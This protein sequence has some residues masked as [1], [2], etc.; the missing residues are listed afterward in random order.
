VVT[1]TLVKDATVIAV[2]TARGSHRGPFLNIPPTKRR[3]EVRGVSKL[4][5]QGGRVQR[6]IHVWDVAGLLRA[7]GLL[8]DL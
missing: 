6:D 5:F 8:P 7:I 4:S 1:E 2:W 3:F